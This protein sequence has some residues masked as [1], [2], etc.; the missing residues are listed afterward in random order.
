MHTTMLIR[1]NHFN[2]IPTVPSYT[3]HNAGIQW[4]KRNESTLISKLWGKQ[5]SNKKK[6]VSQI[7]CTLV[8]R[9]MQTVPIKVS[10]ALQYIYHKIDSQIIFLNF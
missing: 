2:S 8:Y 1:A 4:C 5:L 9:S 6:K 7:R 3:H 10:N